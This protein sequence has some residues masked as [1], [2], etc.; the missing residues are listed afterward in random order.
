MEKTGL[1]LF[2]TIVFV[3]LMSPL[4]SQSEDTYEK[5]FKDLPISASNMIISSLDS[6]DPSEVLGALKKVSI[7]RIREARSKVRYV[8]RSYCPSASDE[9]DSPQFRETE[10]RIYRAAVL[11][12]GKIGEDMDAAELE[13]VYDLVNLDIKETIVFSLGEMTNSRKA[14]EVLNTL[15]TKIDKRPLLDTLLKAV[16]KHKSK[17]SIIPL[18]LL[19]TSPNVSERT[20]DLIKKVI[21]ELAIKGK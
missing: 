3:L 9:D 7:D 2:C 20:R 19:L 11:A 16:L 18:K 13:N 10:A 15:T 12:I 4:Y 6:M 21:N 5:I 17:T 1:V 8:M 14:L